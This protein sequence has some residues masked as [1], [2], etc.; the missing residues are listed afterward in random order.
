MTRRSIAA[1][2][3]VVS[4]SLGVSL[5]LISQSLHPVREPHQPTNDDGGA[6]RCGHLTVFS[7]LRT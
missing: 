6:C 3:I 4:P 7:G 1:S 2:L 5:S